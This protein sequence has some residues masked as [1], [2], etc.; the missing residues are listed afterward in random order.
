MRYPVLILTSLAVCIVSCSDD[1][2]STAEKSFDACE[3]AQ[4]AVAASPDSLLRVSCDSVFQKNPDFALRYNKCLGAQMAGI[5]TSQVTLSRLGDARSAPSINDGKYTKAGERSSVSWNAS[6]VTGKHNGTVK[7]KSAEMEV[8]NGSII[9]G[10]V[11]MDMSTIAVLD[12]QGEDRGK[13]EGH[14]RSVDFFDTGSFPEA[15]FEITAVSFSAAQV[16]QVTGNLTIK[17]ITKEQKG[18][19]TVLQSGD[20]SIQ[21][22][23]ALA[24]DRTA[25]DIRY[26][27]GK[28]FS[29]L[30]DKAID[31]VF[32]VT[33]QATVTK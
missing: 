19:F 9:S 23:G 4:N 7:L 15:S 8:K 21:I 31:D 25:F 17:G 24:I 6:K 30:G 11:V 22:A 3:C 26:G 20:S 33:V 29:D 27:S 18:T 16:A 28:F 1:K 14:L 2:Q 5:D 12:L 10:K 13:L 32:F